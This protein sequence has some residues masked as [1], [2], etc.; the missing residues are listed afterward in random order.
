M[1]AI[2]FCLEWH[3]AVQL[4]THIQTSILGGAFSV[5]Q[6]CAFALEVFAKMKRVIGLQWYDS[7]LLEGT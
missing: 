3:E 4:Y 6:S 7:T 1:E 5:G 2:V